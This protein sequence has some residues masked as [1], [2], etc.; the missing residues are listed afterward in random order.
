MP[1]NFKFVM[2]LFDCNV[3]KL[4]V[5]PIDTRHM[6]TYSNKLDEVHFVNYPKINFKTQN[7]ISIRIFK[8]Y[9]RV[10]YNKNL[11]LK[12][13]TFWII[14]FFILNSDSQY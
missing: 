6:R 12:K 9:S 4:Q 1:Q 13:R 10:T 14:M 3:E 5:R 8:K 7:F 11:L 2:L